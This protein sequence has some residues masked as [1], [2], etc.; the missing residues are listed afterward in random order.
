MAQKKGQ[1]GN[2]HGRPKG[3]P[4]KITQKLRSRLEKFLAKNW[5]G[6]ETDFKKLKPVERVQIYEKLLKL[7]LPTQVAG[8][9]DIEIELNELTDQQLK[10]ITQAIIE[11]NEVNRKKQTTNED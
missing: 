8:E 4:N 5:N 2:P 1:T 9:F 6:L 11:R 7:I 3:S 10:Q